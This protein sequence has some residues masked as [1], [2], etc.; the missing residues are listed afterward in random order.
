MEDRSRIEQAEEF[1]LKPTN[2]TAGPSRRPPG[3]WHVAPSN[4]VLFD[5][6]PTAS[7]SPRHTHQMSSTMDSPRH[8]RQMSVTMDSPSTPKRSYREHF[9]EEEGIRVPDL[10]GML[11]LDDKD[12][13]AVAAAMNSTSRRR[14]YLL[15][16]EPSSS[17]EAF[18]VHVSV[19]AIIL[20]R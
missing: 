3:T 1:E 11:G 4:S 14:L 17:R 13:F 20:F 5:V 12:R 15:M 19:T 6:N 9:L 7:S 10:S 16:E 18:Y 8:T 2:A